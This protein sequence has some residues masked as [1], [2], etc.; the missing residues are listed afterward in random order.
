MLEHAQ[1]ARGKG[2]ASFLDLNDLD[3]TGITGFRRTLT[4][5][6]LLHSDPR[7]GDRDRGAAGPQI[8]L[9]DLI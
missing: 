4:N 7:L 9:K 6:S 1:E 3:Q 8:A 2:S 5:V